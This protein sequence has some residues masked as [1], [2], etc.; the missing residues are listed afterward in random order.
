M[1]SSALAFASA[2]AALVFGCSAMRTVK[3]T[4]TGTPFLSTLT[5]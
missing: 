2:M 1:T 3:G 5:W 4:T